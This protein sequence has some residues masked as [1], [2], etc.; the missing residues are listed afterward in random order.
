MAKSLWYPL[1]GEGVDCG[2]RHSLADLLLCT[3]KPSYM[4]HMFPNFRVQ[5]KCPPFPYVM[6]FFFHHKSL[7]IST[8]HKEYIRCSLSRINL[9]HQ[10]QPQHY[11]F[12]CRNQIYCNFGTLFFITTGSMPLSGRLLVP[13]GIHQPSS[14]VLRYWPE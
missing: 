13:E 9:R 6:H 1:G 3:F 8:I 5:I 14:P 7:C 4:Y 12:I 2:L 11:T 10:Y